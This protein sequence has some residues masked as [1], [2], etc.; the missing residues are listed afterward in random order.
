MHLASHPPKA[1][2]VSAALLA[3]AAPAARAQEA[4]AAIGEAAAVHA[5]ATA[6]RLCNL[7]SEPELTRALSR[8]DRVHASQLS[9]R[10][11]ET[12]LIL[13]TSDSF[14]NSVFAAALRRARTGCGGELAA[15]W[16][17][18]ESTL[19]SADLDAGRTLAQGSVSTLQRQN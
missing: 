4:R 13:R 19:V 17:D 3:L 18:V 8:M 7:I 12:Y 1:L 2:V 14:R 5:L 9:P 11:Q 6:A 15:S 10:D 16:R